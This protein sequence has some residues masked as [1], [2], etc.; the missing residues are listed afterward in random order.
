MGFADWKKLGIFSN[1]QIGRILQF[2]KENKGKI[3]WG[4]LIELGDLTESETALLK[5]KIQCS[6]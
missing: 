2:K 6:E 4:I 5:Q 1:Q 3:G